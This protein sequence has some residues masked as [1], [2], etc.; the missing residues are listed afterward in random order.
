[1]RS[2]MSGGGPRGCAGSL[3]AIVKHGA[4]TPSRTAAMIGRSPVRVPQSVPNGTRCGT[5][6]VRRDP[7]LGPGAIVPGDTPHREW[8]HTAAV[9]PVDERDGVMAARALLLVVLLVA[10]CSSGGSAPTAAPT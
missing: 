5:T 8:L 4:S 1:M 2:P 3:A 6:M 7:A 10:A 9:L